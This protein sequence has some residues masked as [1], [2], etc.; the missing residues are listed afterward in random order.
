[1][2][3]G[4]VDVTFEP[5]LHPA[6]V[7][8]RDRLPGPVGSFEI[9]LEQPA[10]SAAGIG[11]DETGAKPSQR[12]SIGPYLGASFQPAAPTNHNLVIGIQL[13]CTAGDGANATF[14]A[15]DVIGAK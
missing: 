8:H 5:G 10:S 7:G 2:F 14:G 15:I 3:T 4:A 13:Q 9:D 12:I 6:E 11:I 1:M